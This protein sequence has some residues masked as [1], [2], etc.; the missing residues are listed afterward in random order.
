MWNLKKRILRMIIMVFFAVTSVRILTGCEEG[1]YARHTS[2][3]ISVQCVK[4]P[5][6]P[7]GQ[8]NFRIC[9]ESNP[10]VGYWKKFNT[11]N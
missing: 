1:R 2:Q 9:M 11:R 10:L 4:D 6:T 8:G 5:V 7:G 3:E